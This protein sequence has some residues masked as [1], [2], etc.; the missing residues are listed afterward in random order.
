MRPLIALVLL[1]LTAFALVAHRVQERTE[2]G[3]HPQPSPEARHDRDARDFC[4][5]LHGTI[6]LRDDGTWYCSGGMH[7]EVIDVR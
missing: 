5:G 4:A 3:A 2:Q 1:V 6:I 7:V